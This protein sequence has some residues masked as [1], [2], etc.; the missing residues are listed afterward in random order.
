MNEGNDDSSGRK[1][2]IAEAL[3]AARKDPELRF[4]HFIEKFS[5]QGR[6]GKRNREDDVGENHD[7]KSAKKAAVAEMNKQKQKAAALAQNPG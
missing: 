4:C 2:T 3:L 5:L 1:L 6:G 7:A